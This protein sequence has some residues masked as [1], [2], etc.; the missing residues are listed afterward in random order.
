MSILTDRVI[1]S[2]PPASNDLI[3][4]VDVSDTTDNPAG[5]SF[6][7]EVSDLVPTIPFTSL[8]TTGTTGPSTLVS[9]ILNVPE[10][11]GVTFTGNTSGDCITD[12]HITNLYGCSP[13]HIEPSGLSDVYMVEN[14][15]N[16]AIGH[17]TPTE[18]LHV[19]NGDIL[20]EGSN[21]KVYSVLSSSAFRLSA[22]T[23]DLSTIGVTTPSN[24]ALAIGTRGSTAL[25]PGYGEQGD[26]FLYSSANQNGLNIISQDGTG[27]DYIRFYAGK[28]CTDVADMFIVG[29]QSAENGYIGMGTETPTEKLHVEGSI[30]MVDGNQSNGYVLT[31]DANG[32]G[33]WQASSGGSGSSLWEYGN[34]ETNSLMDINGAHTQSVSGMDF[35]ML[36]GGSS[37]TGTTSLYAFIAGGLNNK[38]NSGGAG[39]IGGGVLNE[40][41]AG[42]GS[43]IVGGSTNLISDSS[44]G[45]FIAGGFDNKIILNPG[46]SILGGGSNFISGATGMSPSAYNSIIGGQG[47]T[48]NDVQRSVI[49]G[50]SG[51]TATQDDTVYLDQLNVRTLGTGTS[52][53]NLGIDS[54]GNVVEATTPYTQYK[55]LL[56]QTGTTEPS[57]SVLNDT[58]VVA[59][60]WTYS[61][62]GVYYFTSNGTFTDVNKVEVY[63]P[64]VQNKWFTMSNLAFNLLS[65][66]RISNDVIEVRT[67]E[68]PHFGTEL[69][70]VDS[71]IVLNLKDN[72]LSNTPITI[73]V[74]S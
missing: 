55:A 70:P 27:T 60:V 47:N 43:S 57:A 40:I 21:G 19:K 9:G 36:A 35:T 26:G 5:T 64:G 2:G 18:K 25:F 41:S 44:T 3:H 24:G 72:K 45:A 7:I 48:L 46:S 61:T 62:Q 1:F 28:D 53:N 34:V 54:S 17:D 59:G 22:G 73:R 15:G 4:I 49:L 68:V 32:V 31:S 16:V 11:A 69:G 29:A 12:L 10:Y 39:F 50:S 58:L 52:V 37:N 63:I 38:L 67:A 42:I 13:L 66:T 8:T 56:T 6:A 20:V 65:A 33:S 14:G 30:K 74:W 23:S 51:I 71:S